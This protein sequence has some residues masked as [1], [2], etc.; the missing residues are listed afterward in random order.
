MKNIKLK[1]IIYPAILVIYC[2][3]AVFLFFYATNFLA[4]NINAAFVIDESLV[5]SREAKLDMTGL[6]AV[7]KKLGFV[8]GTQEAVPVSDSPVI[9]LPITATTTATTTLLEIATTTMATT[10]ATTTS[11]TTTTATTTK[12]TKPAVKQTKKK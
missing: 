8:V 6:E 9:A 11:A 1:K 12:T 3:V 5:A 2:I 4:K 10:I 7:G